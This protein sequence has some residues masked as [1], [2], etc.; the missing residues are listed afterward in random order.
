MIL[1]ANVR[2]DVAGWRTQLLGRRPDERLRSWLR[3][4]ASLTLRCQQRCRDF[5][6]R[7]LRQGRLAPLDDGPRR[8][9]LPVREV[10]LEC[11]GVP[12]IFAHSVLSTTRSGRLGR[13]FS[14]LGSQSLGSLL[15]RHPGFRR[16]TIEFLRLDA[17]HPLHRRVSAL[18]GEQPVLWAR[19]SSHALAGDSVLVI[20]V[21]LPSIETLG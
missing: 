2:A 12:V 16:D 20:E 15:F 9:C 21:F 8:R 10:L 7:V 19:R 1:R 17:R 5:R 6:V 4:T 18:L 13:W 11:D 14:R 3:E